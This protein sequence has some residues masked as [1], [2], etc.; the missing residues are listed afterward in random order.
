MRRSGHTV[1]HFFGGR[2]FIGFFFVPYAM[3][4]VP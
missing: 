4:L 2:G 1:T 3:D